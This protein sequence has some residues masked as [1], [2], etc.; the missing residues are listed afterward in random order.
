MWAAYYLGRIK[1]VGIGICLVSVFLFYV[2]T[3]I[4]VSLFLIFHILMHLQL[5]RDADNEKDC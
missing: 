3:I 2:V 1:D 5:N 4:I